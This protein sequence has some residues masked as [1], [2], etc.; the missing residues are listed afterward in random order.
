MKKKVPEPTA[1]QLKAEY[2]EKMKELGK[3]SADS[4]TSPVVEEALPV[5]VQG[6]LLLLGPDLDRCVKE[7]V[8][9]TRKIGGVVNTNL[10]MAG[11]EVL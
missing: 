7:Y 2:I 8:E 5:K 11:A 4:A 3:I 1:R 6:R 9:S 10:V